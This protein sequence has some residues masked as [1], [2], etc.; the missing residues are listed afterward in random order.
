MDEL[1][2]RQLADDATGQ[3]PVQAQP[4]RLGRALVSWP[5]MG[6]AGL[7]AG[8]ALAL[9]TAP[10]DAARK[11]VDPGLAGQQAAI[12]QDVLLLH[13]ASQPGGAQPAPALAHEEP[14]KAEP[15]VVA[16]CGRESSLDARRACLLGFSA[17]DGL[18][19]ASA[20][21]ALGAIERDAGNAAKATEYWSTYQRR[22]P[23]G[24]LAPEVAAGLVK[25]LM[26]QG[27][28]DEAIAEMD[29]AYARFP[30]DT[31]FEELALTKANLLCARAGELERAH[32]AYEVAAR[33]SSFKL[34]EEALFGLASCELAHGT[35]PK[36]QE[37]L[38]RYLN[39]FPNG[40]HAEEFKQKLAK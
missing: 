12:H 18:P 10:R 4:G 5:A 30:G 22:F 32:A 35:K 27:R 37:Y 38:Q 7:A 17:G 11:P 2:P 1:K 23:T 13:A 6:A 9:V 33:A 24:A 26:S 3:H 20:L 15:R 39:D 19:A 36:A 29:E 31:R 16:D 28:T 25:L 14:S 21:Y 34:R 40:A 8:I